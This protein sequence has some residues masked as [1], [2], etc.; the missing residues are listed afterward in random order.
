MSKVAIVTDSTAY[1]PDGLIKKCNITV[2]PLA[3]VWGEEILRDGVDIT[4]QDFYIRLSSAKAMPTTSQLTVLQIQDAFK[5]L[6]DQGYEVLAIFLS[7]KLS[8]SYLSALQA[9]EEML[10]AAEK[11]AIVDS[12]TTTMAMG[13]PVLTAARAAQA[14]ESLVEVRKLAEHARDNS[15]VLF[16]VDTLE[17]LHRGGRI[18]GAQA[19]L[20]TALNIKPVLE[21]VDG[22]IEPVEKVRT[23]SKSLARV[24]DLSAERIAGRTP[25][26]IATAHAN[27]EAEAQ[28]VLESARERFQPVEALCVPLSPV[29]GTHAGPGCVALNYMAGIE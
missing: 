19:L 3:V 20:G 6:I 2:I 9:R 5:T 10:E 16:V 26:R 22:R 18:G 8:G 12:L 24:L 17:F 27:A 29:I 14:G 25:V 7:S 11:I 23:R 4:P 21:M 13:W 28:E 15:G 1:L